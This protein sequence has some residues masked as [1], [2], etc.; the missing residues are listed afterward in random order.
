MSTAV[1]AAHH[2]SLR[3]RLQVRPESDQQHRHVFGAI[4]LSR[5]SFWA[6]W[7]PQHP[8]PCG[9]IAS[10]ALTLS[11]GGL[12]AHTSAFDQELRRAA[13][14]CPNEWPQTS[15]SSPLWGYH[16]AYTSAAGRTR[17]HGGTSIPLTHPTTSP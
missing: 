16:I 3:C 5:S 1:C 14:Q 17:Q 12:K 8:S 11:K 15:P 4:A 7:G 2:H 9:S 6:Y 13:L 10:P